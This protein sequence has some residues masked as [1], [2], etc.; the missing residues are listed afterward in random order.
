MWGSYYRLFKID[1][2]FIYNLLCPSHLLETSN[3]VLTLQF[4]DTLRTANIFG[5]R[6]C[7]N[8]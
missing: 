6:S 5:S 4:K 7:A 3:I 2:W 1:T 8:S